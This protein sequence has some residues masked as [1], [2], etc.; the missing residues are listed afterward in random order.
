MAIDLKQVIIVISHHDLVSDEV[1]FIDSG[2]TFLPPK[3]VFFT[4]VFI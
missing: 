4:G 1:V 3:K 2:L